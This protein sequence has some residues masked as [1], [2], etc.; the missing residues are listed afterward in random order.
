MLKE[1]HIVT[2][3]DKSDRLCLLSEADYIRTGEPHVTGDDVKTME[4][5][6][7]SEDLLNCHALQFCRL[8]GL[9]DGQNCARRLKGA[10]LNQNTSPPSLY[11]LVKDHKPITPGD[12]L[13][14]RPVCGATRAHNGQLGFMLAKVLDAASD[15]VARDQGT[16]SD[17]TQDMIASIEEKINRNQNTS[18]LVFFSTDVQSLYPKLQVK[19]CA[20][21]IARLLREGRLELEGVNWDQAALYLALTMSRQR[22]EE[23]GLGEVVPRRKGTRGRA[24]GITTKEV[25]APLQEE[26]DWDSSLF[27]PPTRVANEGEK[28]HILSLCVQQGL[29]AALDN[30]MYIWHKGVKKQVGGLAIGLDLSR[31]IGRLVMLEWDKRF[32]DLARNNQ[33]TIYMYKRYVDDSAEGM[34]ALKPG[35]RWNEEEGRMMMHPHLVEEDQAQEQD[36]R[37]MKEVVKMGNSIFD[38]VQLTGDCPSDNLNGKMPLLNTEVWVEGNIVQY[39]DFRKPCSNPMVMLE[40]SAMP[41]SIKRTA[42]SQT[43]IRI[44]RNTRAE[45]PWSVTEELLS[46][47][48][49]RMK[50]SG[51]DQHYRYQV[52][53]S[54][55]EG[56]DKMLEEERRGG[57]PINAPKS[58]EEDRRQRSKEMAPK[59][60]FRKGGYHVPLFVPHTPGEELVKKIKEKEAE[61]NQGRRV[62]FKIV[63]R[64]G[65]TLEEKLKRSNPWSGGRC[66]RARC[67]PCKGEGGGDC[68]KESVCYDLWCEECGVK[69]C[70]YKG[71]SGRNGFTR[72]GEHLDSLEARDEEK[73]VLWLHSVHHHQGRVDVPYR[74]RITGAFFDP[75][76]RQLQERVNITNFKGAILMN[77]RNEMGGV[78]VERTRHRRWAP[79]ERV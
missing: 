32:L 37:S 67:F 49:A 42:L 68:W 79:L 6:K 2:K 3:T 8:L 55:M 70:A 48:S 60:W 61:N 5:A 16:E 20:V 22:V 26:K 62:R 10:L 75:L 74:M 56:F 29:H 77:R 78:R 25:R 12:P 14:A 31:A 11:F 65:V 71:E 28:R 63:G 21:I 13:P 9:C 17:S 72:G 44:R 1:K 52:I 50:L 39:K 24:P 58:W 46:N 45:L 4:E 73:S 7:V 47:F 54:G 15:L 38:M 69:V 33:L 76:D 18:D 36:S 27:L 35:L 19:E 30:H 57:R 23:L 64:G 43:V 51:Y 40:M 41:A 53:K 34:E 59:S 66:G